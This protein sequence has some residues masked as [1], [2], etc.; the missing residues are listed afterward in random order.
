MKN[1]VVG[2]ERGEGAGGGVQWE[3]MERRETA[4]P[5]PLQP[6]I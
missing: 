1:K 6:F 3:Q 4:S 5:L 2:D